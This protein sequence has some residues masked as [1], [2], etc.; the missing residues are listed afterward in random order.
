M[1]SESARFYDAFYSF[2][3]YSAETAALESFISPHAPEAKSLLDVACGTGLHLET[4]RHSYE[5][6]GLDLDPNLLAIAAQRNPGIL[7][8]QGDM[9]SFDLERRFDVVTCLFSSIGYVLDLAGLRRAVTSMARHLSPGGL[10]MIEPWF[11]P[12]EFEDGLV[13]SLIV[14]YEGAKIARVGFSRHLGHLSS[15]EFHYLV[16]DEEGAVTHFA[17]DHVL[18]L[19]S[20]GD[21]TSAIEDAGLEVVAFE[22]HGLMGR[23][24][25]IGRSSAGKD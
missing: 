9:C 22:D 5:A 21:Y 3:D 8:V 7:L 11:S 14:D 1:F 17:E 6:T 23:G 15:I 13:D 19:F 10:L 2:K 4:L 25:Y 12:D 16:R 24:L 18:G 20:P